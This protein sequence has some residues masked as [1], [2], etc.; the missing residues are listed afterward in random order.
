MRLMLLDCTFTYP[1]ADSFRFASDISIFDYDV[2]IWDPEHTIDGLYKLMGVGRYAGKPSLNESNS[3]HYAESLKRRQKEFRDFLSLGRTLVVFGCGPQ[4]M[5]VDTGKREY[6]GTGRNRAS[7]T[8]VHPLDL[9]TA[10]PAEIEMIPGRGVDIEVA[11]EAIRTLWRETSGFWV[12]RSVF[13]S[14]TGTPLLKIA[15]TDKVVAAMSEFESGGRLVILPSPWVDDPEDDNE[16]GSDDENEGGGEEVA[17]DDDDEMPDI[18]SSMVSWVESLAVEINDLP[19]TW[20]A[21]YQFPSEIERDNSIAELETKKAQVLAEIDELQAVQAAEALWKRLGTADGTALELQVLAAFRE[22]GFE[23]EEVERFRSDLRLTH[24]GNLYVVETKGATKS[25]AEKHA[26]Q[27]EKWVA[28]ELESG[29]S[30]KGILVV[31]AWR[32][33][34]FGER[35]EPVFPQQMLAYCASRGHCLVSGLQLLCM[36]RAI[37]GGS[38]TA[39]EIATILTTTVGPV[40]GWSDLG[41]IFAAEPTPISAD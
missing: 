26:A 16:S 27:L 29:R 36:V 13:E 21:S 3:V 15:G 24:G 33:K 39:E 12:Y 19:P 5:Y 7:T 22:F 30:A 17:G 41:E 4:I 10:C 2:V 38:A 34:P 18:V 14:F 31:N 8:I 25:A 9:W 1:G 32:E 28:A 37:H 20:V 23:S 6:S 35:N 40:D 11:S